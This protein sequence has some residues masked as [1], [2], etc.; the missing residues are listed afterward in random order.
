MTAIEDLRPTRK[1]LVFALAEEAGFD[2]TDWI[3]SA[4]DPA[5]YRSNPKYCYEWSFIEPGRVVILNLWHEQIQ[6]RNGR[7]LIRSNFRSDAEYHSEVSRK[8]SWAKRATK[9]DDAVQ[10]AL[11]DNLPVRVILL[12]G[13]R[14]AKED[15]D[16][17]PSQ[18][19]LRELDPDGWTITDYDW[20]TGAFELTR[21]ILSAQYVD[22]FD[23]DLDDKTKPERVEI[24]G[25]AWKRDPAVRRRARERA[26]G[27]CELCGQRG[28]RMEN[29]ALYLETHHIVPLAE[30]GDD[31]VINVAALCPDD[32]RRAH[33]AA[34]KEQIAEQLLEI[35]ASKYR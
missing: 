9:L 12:D 6:E 33:Y 19:K 21:G 8:G 5:R 2:V 26:A 30:D 4:S 23:I 25:T 11:R 14:R 3:E 27:N 16:R 32:H 22:Q 24:S 28:F 1:D 35:V 31:H 7:F 20:D 13:D 18:V 15:P 10:A 17:E 29:G 34:E